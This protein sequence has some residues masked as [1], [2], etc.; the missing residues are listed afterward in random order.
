MVQRFLISY[1][2]VYICLAVNATCY[3]LVARHLYRKLNRSF[4]KLVIYPAVALLVWIFPLVHRILD[5]ASPLPAD[6]VGSSSP[7]MSGDSC[8]A[9]SRNNASGISGGATDSTAGF[10]VDVLHAVFAPSQG[11]LNALM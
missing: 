8:W 10:V 4:A 9:P 2:P 3:Y 1:T 7:N 11:F 5:A 6:R